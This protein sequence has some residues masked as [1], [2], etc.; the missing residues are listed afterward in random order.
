[1][2]LKETIIEALQKDSY[3]FLTACEI[4]TN[5]LKEVATMKAGKHTIY[6]GKNIVTK[7]TFTKK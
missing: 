4:A 7:I 1:M 6:A 5:M 2:T 3:N